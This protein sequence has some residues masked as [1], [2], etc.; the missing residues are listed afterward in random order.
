MKILYFCLCFPIFCLVGFLLPL[1]ISYIV[2][3]HHAFFSV[4][5]FL[6]P[7]IGIFAGIRL[8]ALAIVVRS[9]LMGS[10]P[11]SHLIYHIPGLFAAASWRHAGITVNLF[12]MLVCMGLFWI[13]PVG[14][15][16]WPYACYWLIPGIIHLSRTNIVFWRA[17]AS[18]F[19]AHAVGS[20]LWL[21]TVNMSAMQW[22][23]LIP[24]VPIER[25]F[26]ALG[27]TVGYYVCASLGAWVWPMGSKIKVHLLRAG[28]ISQASDATKVCEE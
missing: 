11:F 13:H 9:I 12:L 26:F 2:G 22:Y 24:I 15:C 20:L 1:K 4:N 14:A 7:L 10:I 18:T 19:V 25:L 21:Y 28:H 23:I 8:G 16:A 3:S 17:L 5:A 6:G 27:M